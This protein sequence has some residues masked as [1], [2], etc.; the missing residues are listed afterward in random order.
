MWG[1][2]VV[3]SP[4]MTTGQFLVGAFSQATILFDRDVLR[5]DLSFENEDDFVRNMCTIRAEARMAL[6]I[7]V[8]VGLVKGAFTAP[9]TLA[10]PPAPA[11]K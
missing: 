2:P 7:P 3:I 10:S 1:V 8:P 5:V 11:A 6:A 9:G 4:S